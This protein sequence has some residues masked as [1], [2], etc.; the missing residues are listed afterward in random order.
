MKTKTSLPSKNSN[1]SN[2]LPIVLHWRI[3]HLQAGDE[4]KEA[5][6]GVQGVEEEVFV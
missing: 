4:G 3:S 6:R 1:N 5:A 2:T